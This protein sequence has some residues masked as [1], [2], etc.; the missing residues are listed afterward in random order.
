M[1][2]IHYHYRCKKIMHCIIIAL[3][4]EGFPFASAL[5]V[6]ISI[7]NAGADESGNA[8]SLTKFDL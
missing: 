5:S 3:F 2:N 6:S 8:E 4:S 7:E 1:E